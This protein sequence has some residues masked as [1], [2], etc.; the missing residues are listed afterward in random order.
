M[1]LAIL[2][3]TGYTGRLVL[4]EARRAGL[5]LRLVGRRREALEALAAPGEEL[6]V[7]DARDRDALAAAFDG[8]SVVA[9]LAGPFLELGVQPVW[10][11]VDAGAQYLDTTGEQEFVRLLH[12]LVNEEYDVALLPAFGFDY[13]PGDLAARLA[14]EQ[15]DGPLDEV[16][17]AYSVKGVG[18]SRGTRRT[19]GQVMGQGQVA[20]A[21]GRLVSSRFGATT[22]TIRFP[23]GER[24]VVEW[25]GTEPLTVPRHTDVRNVRSYIRA[26]AIAAKAGRFGRLAAPIVRL[27][28]RLGP[29]GPS[30]ASRRKSRFTVVA[31]ARGPGGE[32]RAVLTGSD[33][34]GLTARLI[35]VGAQALAAGEA[36]GTGVLAP[37]EAFDA[38]ALAGRLEPFLTIEG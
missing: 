29:A 28:A 38:R 4:E 23:F 37:A 18:T 24:T 9:S 17:V 2:G 19:I 34:Y 21:D 3:V 27:G 15:V 12:E 14:A 26:P 35:V 22:R 7:A 11:A 13:V 36:R 8:V 5:D 6:R 33:V 16:M 31:E 25:G 1:V 20:R 30:E 10:A 32:G